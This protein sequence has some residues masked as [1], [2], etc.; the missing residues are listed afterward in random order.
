LR[1]AGHFAVIDPASPV[2]PIV[3]EQLEA[4]VG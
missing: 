3:M 2:W 4:L 1:G